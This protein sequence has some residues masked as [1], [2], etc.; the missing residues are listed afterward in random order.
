LVYLEAASKEIEAGIRKRIC[1]GRQEKVFESL[2]T[3]G[4]P[5]KPQLD[6]ALL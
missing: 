2:L 4:V 3:L 1:Y 6:T 5:P